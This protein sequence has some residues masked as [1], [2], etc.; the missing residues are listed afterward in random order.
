MP[1]FSISTTDRFV[2]NEY[3]YCKAQTKN[4]SWVDASLD[5]NAHLGNEDGRFQP[6]GENAWYTSEQGSWRLQGVV[7]YASLKN[8]QGQFKEASINLDHY[9]DND[10]GVLKFDY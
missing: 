3:L 1:G 7:L 6:G 4:G 2:E 5:L 9:V 8:R 10:N